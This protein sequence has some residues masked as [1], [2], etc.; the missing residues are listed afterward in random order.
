[1]LSANSKDA[2]SLVCRCAV[3]FIIY[4]VLLVLASTDVYNECQNEHTVNLAVWV[5]TDL[6]ATLLFL[7]LLVLYIFCLAIN[8]KSQDDDLKLGICCAVIF[9]LFTLAWFGVGFA[10]IFQNKECIRQGTMLGVIS[11]IALSLRGITLLG[12][13]K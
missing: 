5:I 2:A 4:I 13:R 10:A 7:I 6:S 8:E 3:S 12:N 9:G 1:M 11:V